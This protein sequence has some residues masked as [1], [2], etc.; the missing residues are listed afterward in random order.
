MFSETD[1]LYGAP[2]TVIV[3][4]GFWQAQFAGDEN[5]IGKN[6]RLTNELYTVIGVLPPGFEYFSAPDVYT[7]LN[8][9]LEPNSGFA[10]RASSALEFYGVARLKRGVTVEQANSEMAALGQ[11]LAQE[12]PKINEGKSAMAER[13]QDVMSEH[14]R[15]S[16]W[17]LLAAVGFILLIACINVANLMLVRAAERQKEIAVRLALG[18]GR[19]RIARQLLTE[20]L[21]I[22]SVGG[23]GG[24]FLGH[25]MLAGLL[26]LAPPDIPQLSRV[27]LDQRVLLFTLCLAA[28]TSFLFGLLPAFQASRTDMQSALKDGGRRATT[29]ARG[30]MRKALLIAEVSLSLVLLTGA[31]LLLRSMYNLMHVDL[32]FNPDNLVTLRV[33]LAGGKYNEQTARVFYDECLARVQALPGVRAAALAHSMPIQGTNWDSV[34][35]VADQPVPSRAD[36]PQSDY[37]RVTPSYFE[38]MGIRLLRGRLFT[39]ADTEKAP[40]VIIINEQLARRIWPSENPIGKRVKQGMPEEK[41]PWR[42]VVGVVN[43]VKMNGAERPMTLQTYVPFSQMPEDALRVVVRAENNPGSLGAAVEQ[44]IHAIDKELPVYST[45]TMD[46]VLGQSRAQRRLI[47]VLLGS[48]AAL[49]L[50][51]AAVGAYGVIAYVVRQRTHELGIRMAL[52]AQTADVL[53]MILGQGMKLALIGIGLGMILAFAFTRWM[54]SLLFE[55]RPIDPLTFGLIALLLLFVA[56]LACWIPARRA[57]KVDPLMALKYE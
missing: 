54:K 42:E 55:V 43:D 29:S 11:Q 12:Y 35:I 28:L 24:L 52:G 17:V 10:N 19:G 15:Q 36:L 37:L 4:H 2:R 53:T 6:L 1:D 34:F 56:L 22:A 45:F 9:L 46:Q 31:G 21:L 25:W 41:G 39:G 18:A 30:T 38:T 5:I 50:L 44:A 26:A 49:A 27:S 13:L 33:S 51:L 47:L 16:L 57:T 40:P 20:S 32:G 48:F 14:V 7:P 3:S 23:A 8:L